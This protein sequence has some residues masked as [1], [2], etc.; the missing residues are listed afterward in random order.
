MHSPIWI[1]HLPIFKYHKLPFSY[2]TFHLP[3]HATPRG[4][5]THSHTPFVFS[6]SLGLPLHLLLC[7]CIIISNFCF[8]LF[9]S[10]CVNSTID[11]FQQHNSSEVESTHILVKVHFLPFFLLSFSFMDNPFRKRNSDN[12]IQNRYSEKLL[13]LLRNSHSIP[14]FMFR[15]RCFTIVKKSFQNSC[16]GNT[17]FV[18][19]HAIQ[20]VYS[21]FWNTYSENIFYVIRKA[22][23][24]TQI[25]F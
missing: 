22:Y 2:Y 25:M 3:Q 18:L 10:I 19:E 16:F 13:L 5:L 21:I 6:L 7:P 23:F 8:F 11:F 24:G 17:I 14:Q 9:V 1:L 20:N 4:S 15:N 12:H